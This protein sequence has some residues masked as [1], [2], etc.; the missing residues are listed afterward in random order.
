MFSHAKCTC[1]MFNSLI[2]SLQRFKLIALKPLEVL[3][4][5]SNLKIVSVENAVILSKIIFFAREKSL[6]RVQYAYNICVKF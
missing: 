2:I 3:I 1:H 6:A 4:T 5:N